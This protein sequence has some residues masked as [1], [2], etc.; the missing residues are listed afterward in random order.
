MITRFKI[1]IVA[2]LTIAALTSEL[3]AG[4]VSV[5]NKGV[6]GSTTA[7]GLKRFDRDVVAAKP[8]HL[9]IYFG[10]NDALNSARLVPLEQFR[11]NLQEM[12]DRARRAEVKTIVLVAPNPILPDVVKKRH[13]KHP[14]RDE[15]SRHLAKYDGAIREIAQSNR[16]PL[17][18]LR[19]M[20]EREGMEKLVRGDPDGVHLTV[21]GYRLL[22]E[23]VA[24]VIRPDLATNDVIV[25]F[26]D[27][28]TFGAHM[29]GAGTATGDTY[30]AVLKRALEGNSERR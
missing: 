29:K 22:G 10:I 7:H 6:G 13:P 27:S 11:K 30:P 17:M 1:H 18:D 23:A 15:L 9:V 4:E 26:G 24:N 25:C 8:N 16:L 14:Q 12:I 21:E 19:H 3:A 28:I 5:L 2:I 20:V